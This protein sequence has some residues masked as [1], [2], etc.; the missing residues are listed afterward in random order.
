V[1][2]ACSSN[3]HTATSVKSK[4]LI[5]I[6]KFRRFRLQSMRILQLDQHSTAEQ[7]YLRNSVSDDGRKQ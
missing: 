4:F 1:K 5:F 7:D 2:K 3:L 6:H